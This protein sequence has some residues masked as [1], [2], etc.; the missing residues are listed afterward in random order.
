MKL[1]FRCLMWVN[2]RDLCMME[3]SDGEKNRLMWERKLKD[4]LIGRKWDV[5][6]S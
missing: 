1:L 4:K 3:I 6:D 5:I 2:G